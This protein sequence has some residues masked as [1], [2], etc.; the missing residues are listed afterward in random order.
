MGLNLFQFGTPLPNKLAAMKLRFSINDLDQNLLP[1]NVN[2]HTG[3]ATDTKFLEIARHYL[4][5]EGYFLAELKSGELVCELRRENEIQVCLAKKISE[6]W[7]VK[8]G[9][10]DANSNVIR[11]YNTDKRKKS[12]IILCLLPALLTNKGILSLEKLKEYIDIK[13]DA[14][15]WEFGTLLTDFAKALCLF[16]NNIYYAVKDTEIEAKKIR[17]KEIE[18]AEIKKV[19]VGKPEVFKL[20]EK[21]AVPLP[22]RGTYSILSHSLTEEE[23]KL[24]PN[25]SETYV[26]PKWVQ[27]EC[28]VIKESNSF[29]QKF[30]NILL[31]GPSGSG[32]TKGTHAMAYLL[33]LPYVKI[34]CSPD[35]EIFD[36]IGQMLPNTDKYGNISV[37]DV[38]SK[39]DIPTLDDV[40]F[41]FENTF[42]RLFGRTPEKMDLPSDC[43]REIVSRMLNSRTDGTAD[44][45]YV[46]SPLIK[47]IRNGWFCEIQE[48]TVIKRSSVLVGLNAVLEND[49]ETSSITLPTGEVV[50]KHPDCVICFTTNRDYEG[51]NII[52]QSVLS[53]IDISREIKMPSASEMKERT[54]RMTGFPDEMKLLQMA[55]MIVKI[56]EFC[57]ER[58]ITDG[59]CGPRELANWAKR[60]I[61]TS[62]LEGEPINDRIIC[63]AAFTTLLSKVSQTLED[64]ED[65]ITGCLQLAY[66]QDDVEQARITYEEGMA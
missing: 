61:I 17:L 49:P 52:Q 41:D 65:V 56:N 29:E 66:S 10:Y 34:T 35:S 26:M 23:E 31:S 40:E 27:T 18:S 33:G 24:L 12:V 36:F 25:L 3:L 43:Y 38:A 1:D 62:K 28:A 9:V 48:P 46:E 44:F 64:A 59:V 51:C 32:K 8:V 55:E 58:D 57:R 16:T 30:R 37:S 50:R 14:D 53:R 20:P 4:T 6:K 42:Q 7:S 15:D 39:L 60:S 47:A 19:L 21:K 2:P 45:T 63:T 13:D 11:E 22:P 5:G 54:L